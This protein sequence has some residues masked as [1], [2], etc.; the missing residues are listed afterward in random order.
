MFKV[1]LQEDNEPILKNVNRNKLEKLVKE[2]MAFEANP[3]LKHFY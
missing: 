3:E 1:E 2:V